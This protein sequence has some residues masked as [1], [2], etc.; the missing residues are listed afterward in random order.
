MFQVGCSA[1]LKR[2]PGVDGAHICVEADKQNDGNRTCVFLLNCSFQ[3]DL[4]SLLITIYKYTHTR[5]HR[6]EIPPEKA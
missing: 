3:E 6:L 4:M 1:E 2:P 5:T